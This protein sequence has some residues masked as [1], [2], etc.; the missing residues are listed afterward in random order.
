MSP[1]AA[2]RHRLGKVVDGH[3]VRLVEVSQGA[4]QAKQA[5]MGPG[6]ELE[7]LGGAGEQASPFGTEGRHAV[8][9]FSC[10]SCVGHPAGCGPAERT[11]RR[12]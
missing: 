10:Q 8:Q 2:Q 5:S 7:D 11:G 4:R 3:L 9:V 6:A 1:L 12:P